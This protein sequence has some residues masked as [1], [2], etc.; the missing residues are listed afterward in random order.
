MNNNENWD[1][2]AELAEMF[3]LF[4]P[5]DMTKWKNYSPEQFLAMMIMEI[6]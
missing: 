4:N 5:E 1:Y 6:K 3:K 2:E